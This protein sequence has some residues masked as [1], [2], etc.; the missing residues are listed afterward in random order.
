[1]PPVNKSERIPAGKKGSFEQTKWFL[2]L[3]WLLNVGETGFGFAQREG[4]NTEPSWLLG[5]L[6]SQG[7][8]CDI[9]FLFQPSQ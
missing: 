7:P 2:V 8:F 6:H 4:E 5:Q 1:M 9:L 3:S